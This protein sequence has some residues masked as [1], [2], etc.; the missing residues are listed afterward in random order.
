MLLWTGYTKWSLG[1]RWGKGEKGEDI[2]WWNKRHKKELEEISGLKG[3]FDSVKKGLE[4]NTRELKE[5]NEAVIRAVER[6]KITEQRLAGLEEDL[7]IKTK[8]VEQGQDP[9]QLF[10]VALGKAIDFVWDLKKD[11]TK[12]LVGKLRE[13]VAEEE[14]EKFDKSLQIFK[15]KFDY[16]KDIATPSTILK[17][18]DDLEERLL[19]AERQNDKDG[20]EKT[21]QKLGFLKE[22]RIVK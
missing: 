1:S 18:K 14:K 3:D 5:K 9:Q 16:V 19:L 22:T 10:I 8:V 11:A 13:E 2:M 6:N 15:K 4:E 20:I 12:K 7:R 17:I 21:K